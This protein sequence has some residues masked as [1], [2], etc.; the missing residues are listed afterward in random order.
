[1]KKKLALYYSFDENAK[2]MAQAKI[3][4]LRADDAL[5]VKELK[6]RSKF[7]VMISGALEAMRMKK[8]EIEPLAVNFDDYGT[9]IL[10]MPAWGGNPAPAMNSVIGLIPKDKE[11][12]IYM[13]S[14]KGN[15]MKSADNTANEI[16]KRGSH[17]TKYVDLKIG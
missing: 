13:V 6:K 8:S 17:V 12:E 4:E 2:K 15:S 10:I 5:E 9:I 1:M 3:K 14:P 7:N 16:Q 11:V